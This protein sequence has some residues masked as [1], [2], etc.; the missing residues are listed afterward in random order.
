MF[1]D[2]NNYLINSDKRVKNDTE[3]TKLDRKMFKKYI[4]IIKTQEEGGSVV[5]GE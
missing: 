5:M 3:W 1:Y 2:N 4:N